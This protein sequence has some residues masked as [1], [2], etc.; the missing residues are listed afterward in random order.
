MRTYYMNL[1]LTNREN[2]IKFISNMTSYKFGPKRSKD[3][4]RLNI[5]AM[6]EHQLIAMAKRI[7]SDIKK[8][9]EQ[10]LK[11]EKELNISPA[12]TREELLELN[13]NELKEIRNPLKSKIVKKNKVVKTE[14]A[15][16]STIEE[17][18]NAIQNDETDYFD[19]SDICFITPMEAY[20]MFGSEFMNYTEN[21]LFELGY[22]IEE[23]PYPIIE[24]ENDPQKI[25]IKKAII[26][27]ILKVTDRYS[28]SELKKKNLEQLKTIYEVET[29]SLRDS[30][31]Y[32]EIEYTIKLKNNK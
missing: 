18:I 19:S 8:Y 27:Y 3:D 30:K 1:P 29:E 25:E 7:K 17:G 2:C 10:I 13:Y 15:P 14:P 5:D 20:Q 28:A 12:H 11:F 24:T 9:I 4:K 22:K 23:G 26:K 32:E 16:L 21:E 6:P 31:T